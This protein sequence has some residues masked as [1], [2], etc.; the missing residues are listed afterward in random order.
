[1]PM[2]SLDEANGE[3]L[4]RRAKMKGPQPNGIACSKCG[5]EMYDSEPGLAL[6]SDPPQTPIKC[7]KCGWKSTRY[8]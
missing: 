7:P 1:M 6:L 3:T 2:K 4:E 5:A 8:F